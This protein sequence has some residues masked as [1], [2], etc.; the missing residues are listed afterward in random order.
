MHLYVK[1][2][3]EA[4]YQL[5]INK[6]EGVDLDEFGNSKAF[7]EYSNDMGDVYESIKE[8]NPSKKR[9]ILVIFNDMIADILRNNNL[10]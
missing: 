10:N 5:L 1:D 9:K 2:P 8:Y 4:K 6:H 7:H 3:Y